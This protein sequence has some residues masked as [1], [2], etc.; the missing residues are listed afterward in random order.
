MTIA[1]LVH[2]VE[3]K[4]SPARAFDLFTSRAGDWWPK[5][6]TL[7]KGDHDGVF[8][9]PRVGG[10]WY[11]RDG[12]GAE[13]QWGEVL[14]WEPPGR[15]LLAWQLDAAWTYRPDLITEVELTF[16]PLPGGGARVTLEHRGFERLGA[17]GA[18]FAARL[19]SGWPSRVADFGRYADEHAE[20]GA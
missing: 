4:A 12:Q 1:P 9:E 6:A 11:E 2:S 19:D 7:C 13:I 5:G 18:A 8:I 17:D 20:V 16:A 14:A 3:V 15:L 10:R